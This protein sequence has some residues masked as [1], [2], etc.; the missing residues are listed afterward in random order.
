[1]N[2]DALSPP[3]DLNP[4]GPRAWGGEAEFEFGGSLD[5]ASAFP[6]KRPAPVPAKRKV[7]GFGQAVHPK[8]DP[9]CVR[10]CFKPGLDDDEVGRGRFGGGEREEGIA[11][12]AEEE[13]EEEPGPHALILLAAGCGY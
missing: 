13:Y 9:Y 5:E 11:A 2:K 10:F 7:A 4:V 3:Q 6:K 12:A 1:M 8:D